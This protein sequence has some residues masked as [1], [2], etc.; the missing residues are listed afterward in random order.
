MKKA[1]MGRTLVCSLCFG[2]A[3][4][5]TAAAAGF[6]GSEA[7]QPT[8][9]AVRL[10]LDGQSDPFAR[11]A[12]NPYASVGAS[13]ADQAF[14]GSFR[15]APARVTPQTQIEPGELYDARSG[16]SGD[17]H[18]VGPEQR[19]VRLEYTLATPVQST[20]LDFAIAPRAGV[21]LGPEGG[22][23]RSLGGE[24]RL[25]QRLEG[26]VGKFDGA[27]A[28]WDRPSWYFFAATD[29]SALTWTPEAM[30]AGARRGIR[31]QEDRV[32]V[33]D[34]QIGVSVEARGVQASLGFTNREITNGAETVDENFVG[35]SFT[36]RR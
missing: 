10:A 36:M 30:A 29:G 12:S 25:G 18:Q 15:V 22:Q 35:A 8:N 6:P 32:V 26:M 31:Y 19:T 21:T 24:V 23:V 14:A 9:P 16:L 27:T 1:N 7:Q 34:A 33:G 13:L 17:Y 4:T 28:T 20:G 11:D 3:I 5:A 2:L